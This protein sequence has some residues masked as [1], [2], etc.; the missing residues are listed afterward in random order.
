MVS[1]ND[2]TVED[3][4]NRRSHS[5]GWEVPNLTAIAPYEVMREPYDHNTRQR[6]ARSLVSRTKR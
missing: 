1:S 4:R 3:A 5:A 2:R 6:I